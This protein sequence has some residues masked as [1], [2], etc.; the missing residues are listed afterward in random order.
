MN[1]VVWQ[2]YLG[3]QILYRLWTLLKNGVIDVFDL[4]SDLDEKCNLDESV[5]Y[6]LTSPEPFTY[7]Q[8]TCFNLMLYKLFG[9]AGANSGMSERQELAHAISLMTELGEAKRKNKDAVFY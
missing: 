9:E 6:I 1:L 8:F 2:N 4:A 3:G 5:S 7:E